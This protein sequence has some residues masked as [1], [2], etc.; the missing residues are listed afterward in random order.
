MEYVLSVIGLPR[1]SLKSAFA[2][3][4]VFGRHLADHFIPH[5]RNN[6][7]PHV[8]GHRAL[9]LFSVLLVT[10][11]IFTI[12]VLAWGSVVPAFSSAITETNIITLTNQSRLD[13]SDGQLT[14]NTELDQAAQAK[15]DDMLAKGYF[16]HV[17]PD[18]RTPWSFITAAGY[19]YLIAGENLAVNF[20][21]AEDVETAWMNS[22][23]HRA[24][25]LNKDFKEIGIG[26]SQGVYQGHNAIFVVQEFGTPAEQQIAISNT[27][28]IVQTA[29]VPVPAALPQTPAASPAVFGS[30]TISPKSQPAA[31]LS[32]SLPPPAT[33]SANQYQTLTQNN[34]QA[35]SPAIT[36]EDGQVSLDKNNV[37]ITAAVSGTA[38]KVLAYFGNQAIMLTATGQ[39]T[40]TGTVPASALAQ[41]TTTVKLEATDMAGHISRLQLADFSPDTMSNYNLL[42]Q[43]PKNYITFL[44]QTFNPQTAESKF[45]LLF[46]AALL[47]SLVIA[48]AVKRHVQHLSLIANTS[49]VIILAMMLWWGGG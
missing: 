3:L 46:A 17:T 9:A 1:Y 39:N 16:A 27:P 7:H 29:A 18:G 2:P 24:N 33:P 6:Y 32:A 10:A 11:K 43:A 31:A 36:I 42:G 13:N 15:A 45:Y 25:I 41:T 8:L 30:S 26:I 40:W 12:A 28:T 19:N 20:T 44:G 34:V 5:A 38:V 37:D 22:P 48:I 49:F 4:G 21:E 35:Q 23:G 14:Q 47:T